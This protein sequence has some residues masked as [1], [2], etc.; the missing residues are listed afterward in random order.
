MAMNETPWMSASEQLKSW[1]IC[2]ELTISDLQ[3]T[4]LKASQRI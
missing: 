2:T 4:F 1:G 3:K